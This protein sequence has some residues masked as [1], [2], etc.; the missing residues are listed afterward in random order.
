MGAWSTVACGMGSPRPRP[1]AACPCCACF[2]GVVE[3]FRL[4]PVLLFD[5]AGACCCCCCWACCCCCCC[6]CC[7]CCCC[8][9][10]AAFCAAKCACCCAMTPSSLCTLMSSGESGKSRS[11]D[12]PMD[13]PNEFI[14]P[15]GSEL[16]GSKV[17]ISREP[18]AAGLMPP[19]LRFPPPG[20]GDK[21]VGVKPLMERL[22]PQSSL[23]RDCARMGWFMGTSCWARKLAD[24]A[25]A[26]CVAS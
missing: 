17:K 20:V 6:F 22:V 13:C 19:H 5:G 1:N 10:A 8:W 14:T 24:V 21:P 18:G 15:V 11:T 26:C 25:M 12:I 4:R 2:C 16:F 9:A 23:P 3:R 7:C